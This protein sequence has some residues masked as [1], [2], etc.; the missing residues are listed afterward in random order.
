ML[1]CKKKRSKS[2]TERSIIAAFRLFLL[3]LSSHAYAQS[4]YPLNDPRNPD[5]PCHAAQKQAEQEFAQLNKRP[6]KDPMDVVK[7][8]RVVK[9]DNPV[10]AAVVSKEVIAKRTSMTTTI[11]KHHKKNNR[12][13]NLYFR[14]LRKQRG[15]RKV[16]T[17]YA[18]CFHKW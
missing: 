8:E 12:L 4:Q 14:Y 13:Q 5:C 11:K 16:H 15:L 18:V 1:F 6:E 9:S 2:R 3:L 7:P 17:D 10:A